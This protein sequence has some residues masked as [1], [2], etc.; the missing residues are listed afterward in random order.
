M[1]MGCGPRFNRWT[2]LA[3]GLLVESIGDL[4]FLQSCAVL[5]ALFVCG[6][7]LVR[8][9]PLVFLAMACFLGFSFATSNVLFAIGTIFGERLYFTPSLGLGIFAA[10]I[11]MV[12]SIASSS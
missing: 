6:I 11:A 2:V 4:R 8:R 10:W 12:V 7:A 1:A 5:T 3:V 9:H